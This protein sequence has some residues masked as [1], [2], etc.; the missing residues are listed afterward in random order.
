MYQDDR[1]LRET[2]QDAAPTV[3]DGGVWAYLQRRVAARRRARRRRLALAGTAVVVAAALG[4]GAYAITQRW[5]SHNPVLVIDDDAMTAQPVDTSQGDVANGTWLELSLP[6]SGHPICSQLVMDPADPNVLY[7][8][9]DVGLFVSRDGAATW[10][11]AEAFGDRYLDL[12]VDPG[13]PSAVYVAF[14]DD[15]GG[16][17]YSKTTDGGVTWEENTALKAALK[18]RMLLAVFGPVLYAR[19][20]GMDGKDVI[21]KSSDGGASWEDLA[22]PAY[23]KSKGYV[24]SLRTDPRDPSR[25]Y[26]YSPWVESFDILANPGSPEP[27]VFVSK[28]GA[29]TWSEL[30]GEELDWAKAVAAAA[31]PSTAGA[32]EAASA[33]LGA[34]W[35]SQDYGVDAA[36]GEAFSTFKISTLAVVDPAAPSVIYVGTGT[37]IY[38]STD[39]GRTWNNTATGMKTRPEVY[40]LVVDPVN[41]STLYVTTK[42]TICKSTDDGL[43]WAPLFPEG[44]GWSSLAVA[45]SFPSRLYVWGS[46]GLSRSDDGGATWAA[47]AG[48]GLPTLQ[49]GERVSGP[50]GLGVVWDLLVSNESPD[51]LLA[52]TV[53]GIRR[54]T[55]GGGTWTRPYGIP[56]K[57]RG[58]KELALGHGPFDG[59]SLIFQARE[60]SYTLYAV[61]ADWSKSFSLALY[62]SGDGG[63]TWTTLKELGDANSAYLPLAMDTSDPLTI[64][65]QSANFTFLDGGHLDGVGTDAVFRRSTDAGNTWTELSEITSGGSRMF[66]DLYVDR[67]TGNTLYGLARGG[68]QPLVYRSADKGGLWEELCVAPGVGSL[69]TGPG[70]VLYGVGERTVYKWTPSAQQAADSSSTTTT[71]QPGGDMVVHGVTVSAV[72]A[73]PGNTQMV[74]DGT[75]ELTA[76]TDPSFVVTVGNQG[77]VDEL[78][79]PVTVTLSSA[80]SAPQTVTYK[81]PLVKA[82]AEAELTVPGPT[83]TTRGEQAT[84]EV[85]VG[86]VPGERYI[87]NNSL[88]ATLI[89]R[90]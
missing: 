66:L 87:A 68:S 3:G 73:M 44:A 19:G 53:D 58:D 77:N 85:T 76:S 29:N 81:I 28:D 88:T 18:D 1:Q 27:R 57:A 59:G 14:S 36:T 21:A 64:Y 63:A 60:D 71:I 26:L 34:A 16:L 38:K 32:V 65:A 5:L 37:G 25:L 79:V 46:S 40:T 42:S 48:V 45:P 15:S 47:P 17:R 31:P 49:A 55:D 2:L 33:F 8:A 83:P 13:P 69:V 43:S 4:L 54:S 72:L 74:Q 35:A 41:A 80:S 9:T 51:I 86:P 10:T 39:A 11:Q 30:K 22:L 12:T 7:A 89:F 62:T 52:S 20:F 70:G 24:F 56:E 6:Q 84:L 75:Y 78:E 50:M 23:A 61:L 82:G 90:P 67:W